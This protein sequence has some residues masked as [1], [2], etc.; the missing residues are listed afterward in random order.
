[1]NVTSFGAGRF[2]NGLL[3]VSVMTGSRNHFGVGLLAPSVIAGVSGQAIFFT[4]S[5]ND[6]GFH[7]LV[8]AEEI[9]ERR[10]VVMTT[11]G[12]SGECRD[13]HDA[14]NHH[15]CQQHCQNSF[16][17]RKKYLLFFHDFREAHNPTHYAF[18][19]LV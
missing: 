3:G 15:E 6:I 11:S 19:T 2:N 10:S 12:F 4:G 14:E 1:M 7:K 9:A 5:F 8:S 16:V 17:H 18:S 13:R